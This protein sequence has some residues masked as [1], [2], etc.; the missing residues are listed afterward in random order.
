MGG[1]LLVHAEEG[2]RAANGRLMIV[3]TSGL[4]SY[5]LTRKFY[6]KNAYDLA[7]TLK[8]FYADGMTWCSIANV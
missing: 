5:N 2:A 3:E 7:G 4:A 1:K 8:D 6:V